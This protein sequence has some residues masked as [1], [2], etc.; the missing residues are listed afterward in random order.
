MRTPA[1]FLAR[2]LTGVV[3]FFVV[4]GAVFR[5]GFYTRYL[6]PESSAG[7]LQTI[8]TNEK[9]R[10]SDGLDQVLAIGDSRMG[11]RALA[12]NSLEPA[13]GYRF[14]TIA[15]PGTTPRC[16]YYMLREVDP[17]ASRYAAILIGVEGYDDEDYEEL[18]G[19]LLDLRYLAPLLQWRDVVDF[20]LS[21]PDWPRRWQAFSTTVVKGLA[22]RADVQDL[23]VRHKYRMRAT[24]VARR[25]SAAFLYHVAWSSQS[26]AG[27]AV[28][29]SSGSITYPPGLTAAQRDMIRTVLLRE[30]APQTGERGAYLTKWYGRV[31]ARYR[32]SRTRI[33]F[34][35]LPRG[36]VVRPMA[37]A[38]KTATVR[39]LARANSQVL[40]LPEHTFDSL[41]RGECFGD[42]MHLNQPGSI[43]FSRLAAL[44]TARLLKQVRIR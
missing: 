16:W 44:E 3:I 11:F 21:Y 13:T 36:P 24:E 10:R 38:F 15:T 17:T 37:A 7:T 43:E 14:A 1:Q 26:M 6:E 23:L 9:E 18:S 41:E 32:G 35:R 40:L 8:L 39:E 27:L 5:S 12:A 2:L 28:D 29:W 34:L 22:M 20:P 31:L 4:E 33:I 42:A 25:E 19:R 30:T